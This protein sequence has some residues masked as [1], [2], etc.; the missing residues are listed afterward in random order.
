MLSARVKQR[1]SKARL[2]LHEEG[3]LALFKK[4]LVL[5]KQALCS[6]SCND[7]YESALDPPPVACRVNDLVL[8]LVSSEKEFEQIEND[9]LIGEGFNMTR[10]K[11]LLRLGAVL[12]C[13]FVGNELVH[14]TQIFIGREAHEI[15][16]FS[17]AMP[18]GHTVGLAWFTAP[19]YRREGIHVYTQSRVLQY[20]RQKGI[21][22]AQGVL[23]KDNIAIRDSLIKIDYYL[24]DEG[25]R[26]RLFSR[27]ILEWTRPKIPG[28]SRRKRF[29]LR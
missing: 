4:A 2:I 29:L 10:N 24:Y 28:A 25:C 15:Y 12:Y 16:P 22:R 8:K 3:C 26:L 20:L 27:F 11:E 23:T 17:F 7:I 21:L 19:K 9:Y 5:L 1:L 13:A 18:F 14:M 6:Y